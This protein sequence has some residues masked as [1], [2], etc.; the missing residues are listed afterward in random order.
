M[1]RVKMAAAVLL[2]LVGMSVFTSLWVNRRCDA[3]LSQ[4]DQIYEL[5]ENGDTMTV[6]DM[7]RELNAEWESFREGASVLLK[8][9]RLIE[10]DRLCSRIVHLAENEEDEMAAE[11]AE[12]R[13]M[14]EMLKSGETPLLTSVL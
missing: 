5:A 6:T 11:L 3:M 10:I 2:L 7:A 12:L 8:Y 13:D 4:V 14:L 1:T 9:D